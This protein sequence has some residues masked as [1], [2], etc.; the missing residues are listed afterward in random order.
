MKGIPLR[1]ISLVGAI[2][3]AVIGTA[4]G[5]AAADPIVV[6]VHVTGGT[7]EVEHGFDQ[8]LATVTLVGDGGFE[9][10][11]SGVSL[12]PGGC[13]GCFGG[14]P[15]GLPGGVF[16]HFGNV[17]YGSS[18]GEFDLFVGGGG[19]LNFSAAGF[20]LP[21]SASEP[22]VFQAPFTMAGSIALGPEPLGGT[23]TNVVFQLAGSGT[24]TATFAPRGQPV[25]G[26]GQ[27]FVFESA[28]FQFSDVETTPE[29]G[30]LLLIGAGVI[31]A[32]RKRAGPVM[33]S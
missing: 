27:E 15:S 20:N 2:V 10:G 14:D 13:D 8:P 21:L 30:T 4:A 32:R 33:T 31:A 3:L 23:L 11:A 7:V 18:S 6:P 24:G 12:V 29:P 17:T 28:V 22:V 1:G 5:H 25:P 16:A 9:L 26:L 19:E